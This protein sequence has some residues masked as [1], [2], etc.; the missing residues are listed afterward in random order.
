MRKASFRRPRP[1]AHAEEV[2]FCPSREVGG[3]PANDRAN[4]GTARA[5]LVDRHDR[6]FG[7]RDTALPRALE[8][9]P[10]GLREPFSPEIGRH[11]RDRARNLSLVARVDRKRYEAEARVT[12]SEIVDVELELGGERN[13]L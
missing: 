1:P 10:H 7:V 3:E 5:R 11:P 4:Y 2:A 6:L 13:G 9:Q 12:D 8:R